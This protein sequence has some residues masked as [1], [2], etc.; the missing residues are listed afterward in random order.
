MEGKD[1]TRYQKF[2]QIRNEYRTKSLFDIHL[3]VVMYGRVSTDRLEQKSSIANQE[4]FYTNLIMSNPNWEYVGEY[5]DDGV[6]GASTK[7]R[8]EFQR[9]ITDAMDG[10]FDLIITKE[11]SRFARNT[12][13]SIYFTR[14]LLENN[15]AVYFQNDNINTL[16]DDSE[17][18]L[19]I[20]SGIAQE[21]ITKLSKR[22]K[23]GHKQSIK[24]GTVFGNSRIYGYTKK[25]G[26]LVIDEKEADMVRYIFT[27]YAS[28]TNSTCRLV[29]ELYE[30][31]YRNN[32]GGKIDSNV[33][34]HII[35]NP[36]YKGYY[37]GGKVEIVDIFSKKQYFKPEEEWVQWKDEN[38]DTVPQIVSEELWECANN[39]YKQRSEEI[40]SHRHSYKT[41]NLFTG[42]LICEEHQVAF[43]MKQ[44]K[45]RNQEENPRW[46]CSYKIRHGAKSCKTPGI[47]ESELLEVI[48]EVINELTSDI[49]V[50]TSTYLKMYQDVTN[51]VDVG[52]IKQCEQDIQVI[53]QKKEKILEYNLE[54]HITD[55]EFIKRNDAY[56]QQIEDLKQR[57]KDLNGLTRS[58]II[59]DANELENLIMQYANIEPTDICSCQIINDLIDKIYVSEESRI[60]SEN[61]T[62]DSIHLRIVLN[63]G[64]EI[65]KTIVHENRAKNKPDNKVGCSEHTMLNVLP[66]RHMIITISNRIRPAYTQQRLVTYTVEI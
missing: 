37:C 14:K 40:K 4:Q 11:I 24:N 46:V 13:D 35:T 6:T 2:I 7:N 22:V 31:G 62:E 64:A 59:K 51:N 53:E 15:V 18:R 33:I 16:D 56:N 28:G 12:L 36:K 8:E 27:A 58:N 61:T 21:E 19:T 65:K 25:D 49:S 50:V 43:W 57:I 48:S 55:T 66:E 52:L 29:E 45:I 44:H 39:I 30:M 38:G 34:K 3:R 32:K 54:G 10:K 42:K 1:V 41:H 60:K 5:I 63:S 9:M 20:M 26:K 17:L 23:F 47:K